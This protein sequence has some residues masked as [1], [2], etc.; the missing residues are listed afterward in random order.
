MY[1]IYVIL[2]THIYDYMREGGNMIV[3]VGL[4]EGTI[5]KWERKRE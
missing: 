2:N 3:I 4:S 1:T 5:G